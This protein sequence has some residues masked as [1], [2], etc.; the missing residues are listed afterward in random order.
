MSNSSKA[1]GLYIH[2][3]FCASKCPYCDFYSFKSDENTFDEYTSLL[4]SKIEMWS[5]KADHNISTVYFG[6][7]TPSILGTER[8]CRISDA[9]KNSFTLTADAEVTLEVNPDSGKNIDFNKLH[10]CGFSRLSVGMQSAVSREL[11]ALGRIHTCED[12]KITVERAEKSGF[13]NI[14]LD[15]MLGIPHQTLASLEESIRF[16]AE[17][18]VKH[19][20]S[21]ILKIEP[22]TEFDKIKNRLDLPDDDSQAELYLY[23]VDLL[24]KLGYKQYEISNF[25]KSGYESKHNI[26]Y[27]KCGE[28][29]GI[30][31]SAHSFYEGKRFYCNR[32]I[33]EFGND[34]IIFDS[35][36]GDEEEF[37]MLS[38]RLKSGLRFDE[39]RQHFGKDLP[40]DLIN[41]A[42]KYSLAGYIDIDNEKICFTP[43]GFL[44][45]NSIICEMI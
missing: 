43:K 2:I 11:K 27:W 34:K 13:D 4:I 17:R 45:S 42:K 36:G 16:C 30:G 35:C 7:G 20:S 9:I 12:A 18:R 5:K 23:A 33:D 28:Y 44:V 38:L 37:I 10:S 1:I 39:Y 32:S 29:I 14:S 6:G 41:T 8:L 3:P 24:D 22:D 26:N 15:L 19:I 25:A 31:P 21:Y 40:L